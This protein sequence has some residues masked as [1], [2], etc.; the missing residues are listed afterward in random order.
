MK[1][2]LLEITA[3]WLLGSALAAA[4]QPSPSLPVSL[5]TSVRVE[6]QEGFAGPLYVTVAGRERKVADEAINAWLIADGRQIAYSGADGAGGYENEGQ[7]LRL[8]DV[9]TNRARKVLAE[10]AAITRLTEFKTKAGQS[11]LIVEMVDGGLGASHLAIV[12]PARGEVFRQ[13]AAKLVR[14]QGDFIAVGHYRE[15]DWERMAGGASVVPLKISRYNLAALLR[16]P[17]ITHRR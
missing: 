10:T 6:K 17:L 14:Q 8:Y 2:L 16:R 15:R 11:G 7:S 3:A 5:A 9:A 4:Q 13:A 1:N 12:D